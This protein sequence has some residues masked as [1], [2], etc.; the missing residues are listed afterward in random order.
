MSDLANQGAA[1]C[2]PTTPTTLR[3]AS[4]GEPYKERAR[5]KP[6]AYNFT[7]SGFAAQSIGLD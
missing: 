7:A 3:P 2:A 6:C 1:C 5:L 4:E